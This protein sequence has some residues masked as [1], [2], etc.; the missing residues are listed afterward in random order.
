MCSIIFVYSTKSSNNCL[1]KICC[2]VYDSF[3]TESFAKIEFNT[4][5]TSFIERHKTRRSKN[6][7]DSVVCCFII[8][9]TIAR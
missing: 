2:F 5:L 1:S 4:S 7:H 6:V 8:L 9:R 3:V